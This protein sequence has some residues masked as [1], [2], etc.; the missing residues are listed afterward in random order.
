M[1]PGTAR[2]VITSLVLWWWW[3]CGGGLFTDNNTKP[4]KVVLSCLGLLVGLWQLWTLLKVK[5]SNGCKLLVNQN[6]SNAPHSHLI[7]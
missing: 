4:T 1:L 5:N 3:W 6:E 7:I 2:I